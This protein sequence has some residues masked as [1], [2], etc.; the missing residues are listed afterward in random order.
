[1]LECQATGAQ[2]PFHSAARMVPPAPTLSGTR[3][4]VAYLL[5][6][7]LEIS[8]TGRRPSPV[9]ELSS[10]V[11]GGTLQIWPTEFRSDTYLNAMKSRACPVFFV[12][13]IEKNAHTTSQ[14]RTWN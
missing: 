2:A 6:R 10:P 7:G 14:K 8:L 4:R 1:M 9:P 5:R 12:G 11:A 13:V 3:W